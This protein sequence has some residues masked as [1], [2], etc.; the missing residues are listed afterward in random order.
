MTPERY[1]E[2]ENIADVNCELSVENSDLRRQIAALRDENM[3]ITAEG[4]VDRYAALVLKF[5][6]ISERLLT[7]IERDH[8]SRWGR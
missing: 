2:L 4:M 6:D 3:R 7:I 5:S 1:K 8:D